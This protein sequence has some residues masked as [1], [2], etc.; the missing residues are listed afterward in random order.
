MPK[1]PI[2]YSKLQPVAHTKPKGGAV[3][4]FPTELPLH[5]SYETADLCPLLPILRVFVTSAQPL[6]REDV[7]NA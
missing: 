1:K 2:L 5:L 6:K 7:I 3:V 4:A